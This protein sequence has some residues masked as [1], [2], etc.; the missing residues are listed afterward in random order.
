MVADKHPSG[1]SSS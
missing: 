1:C